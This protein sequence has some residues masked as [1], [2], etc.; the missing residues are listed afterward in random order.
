MFAGR[1]VLLLPKDAPEGRAGFD[2]FEK[3]L[4]HGGRTYRSRAIG[5]SERELP[6]AATLIHC[7]ALERPRIPLPVVELAW[8]ELEESTVRRPG[9]DP[10]EAFGLL[11]WQRTQQHRVHDAEDRGVG[12]DAQR[13]DGDDG[14]GERG[15]PG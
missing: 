4:A 11:E 13:Q 7:H 5:A 2:D 3:T 10:D 9:E 1:R 12:A 6:E 14:N 15:C 8:R